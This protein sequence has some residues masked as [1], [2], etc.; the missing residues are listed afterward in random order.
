LRRQDLGL[1]STSVEMRTCSSPGVVR[2]PR[3]RVWSGPHASCSDMMWLARAALRRRPAVNGRPSPLE[4]LGRSAIVSASPAIAG[5]F[6]ARHGGPR[7]KKRRAKRGAASATEPGSG[8]VRER[9]A[10]VVGTGSWSER[11]LRRTGRRLHDRNGKRAT[12]TVTW[13]GCRRGEFFKGCEPRCGERGI[14]PRTGFGRV[15]EGRVPRNAA[16]PVRLRGAIDPKPVVRSK[17][18]RW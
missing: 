7:P 8:R 10:A 1:R 13:Y 15:R 14:R 9:G 12:A 18:S 6:R 11:A 16:N 17:P 4:R 5:T 3:I 2:D